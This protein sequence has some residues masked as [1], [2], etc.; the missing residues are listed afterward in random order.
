M[1][2]FR[3]GEPVRLPELAKQQG[4][5]A[6]DFL[7]EKVIRGGM[8]VCALVHPPGLGGNYALKVPNAALEA[9]PAAMER[10]LDELRVWLTL[11]AC[12]G[13]VE[14]LCVFRYEGLP[15]VVSRWMEGGNLRNK[16]SRREPEFFYTTILRIAGTLEWVAAKRGVLHR[17]IKPENILFDDLGRP[18]VS[19]WGI[20]DLLEEGRAGQRRAPS[21]GVVEGKEGKQRLILGTVL[22][23]SPEQ[24]L[25]GVPLDVRTDL[26]SLGT[27]MYEWETGEPPFSGGT[28]DELRKKKLFGNVTPLGG[29]FRK[30]T[31]GA[32]DVIIKCL[33]RDRGHRFGDYRSFIESL[34]E[35]AKERGINVARQPPRLR[36]Q[37]EMLDA[38]ALKG[39][40]SVHGYVSV[41][42]TDGRRT[43][44]AWERAREAIERA[45][46][47]ER[48]ENWAE[49][50]DF[51]VRFFIPS[52]AKDLP[53][54]PLQ[55]A[56]A[57]GVART[58]LR[59][60]RPAEAI[61]S[62]D[63]LAGA[64]VRL[65]EATQIAAG[66][67]LLLGDP[68]QAER[69]AYAA[70]ATGR[71]DE[72]LLD[73]LLRA[74]MARGENAAAVATAR[75][76]VSIAGAVPDRMVVLA[77]LLIESAAELP[78]TERLEALRRLAEANR[79]LRDPLVASSA[80]RETADLLT[81]AL[82]LAERWAE[83]LEAL[84]R[85]AGEGG[86]GP[87]TAEETAEVLLRAGRWEECL[88]RCQAWLRTFPGN[89]LFRRAAARAILA[90]IASGR[91][92]P[93]G[94]QA[95]E[96]A[97]Q[98]LDASIQEEPRLPDVLALAGYYEGTGDRKKALD[99]LEGGR[100]VF[101]GEWRVLVALAG[102]FG[103]EGRPE[104]ALGAAEEATRVAPHRPEAWQA[105][106]A[107]RSALGQKPLEKSAL[108]RAATVEREIAAVLRESGETPPPAAPGESAPAAR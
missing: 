108:E 82:F 106:A 33:A 83:V 78:E 64:S 1:L 59:L 62:L 74:Q 20:A 52:L 57:L 98:V 9:D 95:G 3:V 22:Y 10:F 77:Q 25:G 55:Q 89:A 81:R 91:E 18:F 14:A 93:G 56:L 39:R 61:R 6:A 41:G 5:D 15:A 47:L 94:A 58:H 27:M 38:E 90:G 63:V 8:S 105:L 87:G 96:A 13:I 12:E 80:P 42:G 21:G 26:Y 23:A 66:A 101:R 60:G 35:A 48:E 84:G 4:L 11:S 65:P 19:D 49:A 31:F 86:A 103:R 99:L 85:V 70:L 51:Y 50:H 69:I 44:V 32:D 16:M 29:L 54:D 37:T 45:Q 104:R 71:E 2:P 43:G 72:E 53:D 67:S 7:V 97:R 24:L 28:W 34:V 75:R 36:Y 100:S 40:M 73:V 46:V 107:V 17:D 102:A 92:I 76:L 88:T 79:I 30:S 68:A